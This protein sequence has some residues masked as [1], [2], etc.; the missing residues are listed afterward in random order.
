MSFPPGDVGDSRV[1]NVSLTVQ[2]S[3]R[4]R[5]R[6]DRVPLHDVRRTP[7]RIT[8]NVDGLMQNLTWRRDVL[9]VSSTMIL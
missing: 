9:Y 6:G 1:E 5:A 4:N 7:S 3:G 8:T 2:G